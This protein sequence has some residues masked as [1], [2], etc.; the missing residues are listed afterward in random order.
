MMAFKRDSKV[1]M[2]FLTIEFDEFVF[3]IIDIAPLLAPIVC[4]ADPALQVRMRDFVITHVLDH[5]D[6][7]DELN[8]EGELKMIFLLHIH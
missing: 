4:E 8:E 1:I 6:E 7:I 3:L 5:T 2:T